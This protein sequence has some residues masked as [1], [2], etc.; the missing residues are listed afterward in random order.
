M[1]VLS[2]GGY[3]STIITANVG[4]RDVDI[5][6][7][8][9]NFPG[10]LYWKRNGTLYDLY[11][12]PGVRVQGFNITIPRVERSF[13]GETF[14]CL[15]YDRS[16]EL[17]GE[18][19]TLH[20]NTGNWLLDYVAAIIMDLSHYNGLLLCGRGVGR[21]A[22]GAGATPIFLDGG[23]PPQYLTLAPSQTGS[24]TAPMRA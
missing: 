16:G 5:P 2:V 6:C 18:F 11:S 14:Q 13:N 7:N 17:L 8:L 21:G 1:T 12:V 15:T 19:I 3:S 9:D 24:Q 4:E 23:S 22:R 10:P 20:V